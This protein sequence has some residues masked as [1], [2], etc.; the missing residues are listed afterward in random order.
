MGA[1]EMPRAEFAVEVTRLAA[2]PAPRWH[3]DPVYWNELLTIRP[4]HDR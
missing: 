4:L 2:E 3:F 1:I